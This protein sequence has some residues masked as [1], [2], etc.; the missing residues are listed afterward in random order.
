VELEEAEKYFQSE[1]FQA[2]Y[3]TYITETIE[4]KKKE[5]IEKEERARKQAEYEASPQYAIDQ[6]LRRVRL[7][8][9]RVRDA[10][11]KD[12][13]QALHDAL[14]NAGADCEDYDDDYR[15]C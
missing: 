1:Q 7:E 14:V 11:K 3:Q 5:E 8:Q 12:I 13:L 15:C 10:V 4:R 9:S 2:N 6:E